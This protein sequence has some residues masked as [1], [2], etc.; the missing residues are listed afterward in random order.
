MSGHG[1]SSA[2]ASLLAAQDDPTVPL[3]TWGSWSPLTLATAYAVQDQ[4]LSQRCA[5]SETVVGV[6]TARPSSDN[7]RPGPGEEMTGWLT[8]VMRLSGGAT[9]SMASFRRPALSAGLA[10]VV[11][12]RLQGPGV[13]PQAALRAIDAVYGAVE[14]LDS[15]LTD[16][17]PTTA[18]HVA[19]NASSGAFLLGP[20]GRAPDGLDLSLEA[21]LV[22]V[23]GRVVDTA[24][25]A[26]V[27]GHPGESLAAAAN[28][29]S[30]RGRAVEPGWIVLIG[31]LTSP[32]V[33][34]G[35]THAAIQFTSLGLVVLGVA[36]DP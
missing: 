21:C 16:P 15:R 4:V 28:A 33:L 2:A 24:T 6:K 22:E 30:L 11:G 35:V 8:D 17:S 9:V 32:L 7:R 5:R 25:G 3:T 13:V 10:F 31:G 12:Q 1:V 14:I 26:A 29:L 36:D 20:V 27:R 34:S 18:E 23:D 19:D